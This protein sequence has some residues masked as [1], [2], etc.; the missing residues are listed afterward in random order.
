MMMDKCAIIRL[1][2]TKKGNFLKYRML[3]FFLYW[4]FGMNMATFLLRRN[5]YLRLFPNIHL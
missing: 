1:I 4:V 2:P 5:N 3:P